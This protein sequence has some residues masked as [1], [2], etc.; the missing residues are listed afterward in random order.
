MLPG[1]RLV[2]AAPD[3]RRDADGFGGAIGIIQLEDH[4]HHQAAA[5]AEAEVIE[6]VLE[7][8]RRGFF[9]LQLL[10]RALIIL[11]VLC[12][13]G[14]AVGFVIEIASGRITILH[15][16]LGV[17][18][19]GE[20]G[21]FR[22]L[23]IAGPAL[24]HFGVAGVEPRL[25]H[26]VEADVDMIGGI[27]PAAPEPVEIN[28]RGFFHGAEEIIRRRPLE[29]PAAG[30]FL[31]GEIEQFAAQDGFAQDHQRGGRLGIA[32]VAELQQA[33]A[34]RHQRHLVAADHIFHDIT[35]LAAGAREFR[36]PAPLGL[37]LQEAVQALVHPGPLALV[38]VDDHRE[39]AVADFVDHHADQA[40]FGPLGIGE[41]AGLL[42]LHRARAVEG[43]HRIFHPA[44]RA[45]DALG[46]GIG[47]GEGKFAIDINGVGDG[48]GGIGIPQRPGFLGIEA[49]RHHQRHRRIILA[50]AHRIPHELAAGGPGEIAD[51]L[52]GEAPGLAG[53]G[54]AL[55]G[56]Q[57]FGRR[58]DIH[59]LLGGAG[60]RQP[61]ALRRSQ[62]LG[63][64]Q[65]AGGGHDMIGRHGDRHVIIA[66]LQREL[67]VAHERLVV[68]AFIIRIDGGAREPLRG[69]EQAIAILIRL[70]EAFIAGT[71][72]DH[73][74]F[75]Q[76]HAEFNLHAGGCAAGQRGR[77]IDAQQRVHHGELQRP[78][79]GISHLGDGE[80]AL[81]FLEAHGTAHAGHAD[82]AA[83]RHGFG[84]FSDGI[85]LGILI[86][87][88][89]QIFQR[90]RAVV[91]IGHGLRPADRAGGF[92]QAG[93]DA[94]IHLLLPVTM[95]RRAGGVAIIGR[96]RPILALKLAE[97]VDETALGLLDRPGIGG[98]SHH[99]RCGP[100]HHTP[101]TLHHA[102]PKKPASG[103]PPEPMPI[104]ARPAAWQAGNRASAGVLCDI[105]SY[106]TENCAICP[107]RAAA[108]PARR[109]CRPAPV[110]TLY[111]GESCDLEG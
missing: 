104:A 14:E 34:V 1:H 75:D 33:V 107:R 56:G 11:A 63:V 70:G 73:P 52:R 102:A 78:A 3:F 98:D 51:I 58:H 74:C 47:I 96:G 84:A 50:N 43:H 24:F 81:P 19:H 29:T 109:R 99:R 72:A 60:L 17:A 35:R 110:V 42:V 10:H 18:R 55:F 25:H 101:E 67:A 46:G 108:W 49:H 105:V 61:G 21:R 37:E 7:R 9:R 36:I 54:L 57:C 83:R 20:R 40:I 94:I 103:L 86:Q 13:D 91:V 41:L 76:R 6:I 15:R 39:P 89:P 2:V 92:V 32:I 68:P 16:H 4:R 44:H 88:Q 93:G 28:T 106:V 111:T 38:A 26:L 100:Q 23:A 80:A 8:Q 85:A 97:L 12:R 65:F 90:I 5:V 77:Q 59:G 22:L 71:S 45:I 53:G 95:A 79:G 64:G 48:L 31:E 87:Q 66:K 27:E 30:I 82:L 62:N 69:Q